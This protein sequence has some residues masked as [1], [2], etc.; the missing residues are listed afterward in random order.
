MRVL[1]TTWAWGSHW[2]PLVPLATAAA[3]AGHDVR[4]A[5]AP[6]FG[7]TI[8]TCGLAAVGVGPDL[9][10]PA[11]MRSRTGGRVSAPG[12][13]R[14]ANIRNGI[15]IF[16][17]IAEAMVDD[18]VAFGRQ[19]RPD[20]V[21][22]EPTTFA[23]PLA[24]QVLG[25][26]SARHLWTVDFTRRIDA[27]E[28]QLLGPLGRRFGLD[29][30]RGLGDIT[31]DPCP[32]RLQVPE[33]DGID[34][35]DRRLVRYVP[36]NGPAV[37]PDWLRT[38]PTRRRVAVTWGTSLAGM[39]LGTDT[40][41]VPELLAALVGE[42]V[43]V[44]TTITDGQRAELGAVP[45]NVTVVP[46]VALHQLLP[47]CSAMVHQGGG[48]TL[49][50]G[51]V[52]GLPQVAVPTVPD[53]VLNATRLAAT[54]AARCVPAVDVAEP[55]LLAA[56]V[57][58]LLHDPAMTVAARELGADMNAQPTPFEIVTELEKLAG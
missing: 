2:F 45:A 28:E 31:I 30:V 38:P 4:V 13:D 10:V 26:P 9:D 34:G 51:L 44:V 48:G 37:Y 49:M 57:H 52:S 22:F 21:V 19:W 55:G 32:P 58:D 23:G 7:D 43:E 16:V 6:A 50:T 40:F 8:T 1:F 46:R 56:A 41:R 27:Y 35:L 11:L 42:D 33:P 47:T 3:A 29:R 18:L 24:A 5:S 36:Y 25:V 17:E 15:G 20:V 12:S 39:G 53:Q 14:G 54:G